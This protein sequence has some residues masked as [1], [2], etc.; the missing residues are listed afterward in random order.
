MNEDLFDGRR[1]VTVDTYTGKR[2]VWD[3]TVRYQ[4]RIV[5]ARYSCTA[6]HFLHPDRVDPEL[7]ARLNAS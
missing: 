2:F 3:S 5:P 6:E 7:L 4:G 1:R